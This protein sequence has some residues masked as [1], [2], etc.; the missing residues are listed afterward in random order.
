MADNLDINVIN[1]PAFLAAMTEAR[2]AVAAPKD[3]LSA[4]AREL[5]A[6]AAGAAPRRS[7]RLAGSTKAMGATGDRVRVVADT[8]Y[9]APV[10]WGWP[11]HGI[12]RQPWLVAVWMRSPAPLQK[13]GNGIQDALDKAAAR[14]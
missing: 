3:S 8:P 12:S 1:G 9:A 13:M 5:V 2:Q 14:T 11:G 4:A 7:G 6:Q 10:H